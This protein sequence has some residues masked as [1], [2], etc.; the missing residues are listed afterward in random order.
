MQPSDP[1]WGDDT[2]VAVY[3]A[4]FAARLDLYVANGAGVLREPLEPDVVRRAISHHYPV[5]AYLGSEDGHTPVGA[6]D[7]DTPDGLEQAHK[8]AAFLDDQHDIPSLVCESRRGAHLWVVSLDEVTT[9]QMHRMLRAAIAL[10]LDDKTARDPLVEIFPHIGDGLAVGALRLPGMPHH[11]TQQV[12]PMWDSHK[13]DVEPGFRSL[14]ERTQL[15][16]GTSIKRLAGSQT[17]QLPASYPKHRTLGNFFGFR[18]PYDG[19]N[20]SASEVLIQRWGI[21]NARP[22]TTV[23]CPLHDDRV[24]S[25]TIMKDDSRVYCGS[26]SCGL[27]NGGHGLGSIQLEKIAS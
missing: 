2:I 6:I 11:K 5:S 21:A 8:V 23:K 10:A 18:K 20:V 22:G 26:P 12:Y 1:D 7:F 4:T 19:P 15:T 13:Q 16:T 14:I 3:I 17:P 24:R 9:G 25:L 27:N